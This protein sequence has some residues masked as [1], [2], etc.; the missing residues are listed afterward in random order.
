[1]ARGGHRSGAGRPARHV[2]AGNCL[3]LDVRA[4]ARHG[5]LNGGATGWNWT[6][7]E[8][9]E[10]VGSIRVTSTGTV[11]WLDF[12]VNGKPTRQTVVLART[13]CHFGGSRP[14]FQCP[15]CLTRVGVLFLR[16]G[17]FG[18]RHCGGIVYGSQS[19]DPFGR[20]WR[21]QHRLEARLGPGWRRPKGMH[22]RTRSRLVS[23]IL[24]LELAR[25][26]AMEVEMARL[27]EALRRIGDR[28]GFRL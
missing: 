6:I 13:E 11:L 9:G 1:M 4:L 21:K 14:W 18:C 2:K 7:R 16:G 22:E 19:E 5:V 15:R 8:T 25:E 3:A 12:S 17:L 28:F 27:N 23:T 20:S 26:E 24:E 10:R